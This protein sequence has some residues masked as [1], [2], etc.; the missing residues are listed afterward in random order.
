MTTT[1]LPWTRR[2]AI[3]LAAGFVTGTV[4]LSIAW[5]GSS[6]Q[7]AA[8]DQMRWLN[9]GVLGAFLPGMAA[10][11]W[12]LRGHQAVRQRAADHTLWL[13]IAL[14]PDGP[15]DAADSGP[16]RFVSAPAMT[17]YHRPGCLAA[18]GKPFTLDARAGHERAGR[19]PCEMC[20]P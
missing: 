13:E 18:A 4:L 7:T 1:A 19:R 11:Q 16:D 12:V 15:R 20:R 9:L 6:G 14:G 3:R 17:R 5:F 8:A 10:G 2:D